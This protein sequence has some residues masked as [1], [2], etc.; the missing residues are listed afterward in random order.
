MVEKS[1][2]KKFGKYTT[3]I[4]TIFFCMILY[5]S[6]KYLFS[7][8]IVHFMFNESLNKYTIGTKGK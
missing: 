3:I 2:D 1:Y 5:D 8:K 6:I 7:Q 4:V